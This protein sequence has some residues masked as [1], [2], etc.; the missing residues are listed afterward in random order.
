MKRYTEWID[1]ETKTEVSIVHY[2]MHD[3]MVTL[4]RYEDTELTP[5]Q[6]LEMDKLYLEKCEEV[7]RLKDALGNI[8]GFL[9]GLVE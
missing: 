7:N 3:A 4:G 2:K 8:K 1:E 6:I 9:E 5:E